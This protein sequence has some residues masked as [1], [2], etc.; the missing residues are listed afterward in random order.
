[1]STTTVVSDPFN[2]PITI[3]RNRQW[4]QSI[5]VNDSVSGL[6]ID[7]SQ[8]TL[9]LVIIADL[10]SG[11]APVILSNQAPSGDLINGKAIFTFSDTQTGIL[12]PSGAYRWQYLR[13][14]SGGTNSD[15]VT[16]GPLVVW[17]SPP[18]PP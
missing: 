7:L 14:Q 12:L 8:D 3:P 15:V 11:N 4:N 9:A 16:A 1:V 18:F 13:R 6:P 17:D 10:E 5:T 2:V